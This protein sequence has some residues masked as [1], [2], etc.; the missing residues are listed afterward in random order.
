MSRIIFYQKNVFKLY[1]RKKILQFVL[2]TVKGLKNYKA[3]KTVFTQQICIL[4]QPI[5]IV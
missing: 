5:F 4:P 1:Q 3:E 2:E